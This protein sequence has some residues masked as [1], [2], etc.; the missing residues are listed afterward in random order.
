MSAEGNRT[1]REIDIREKRVKYNVDKLKEQVSL[2]EMRRDSFPYP[3]S[4]P[5]AKKEKN[6]REQVVQRQAK[7][8]Q[9]Q[10]AA[11]IEYDRQRNTVYDRLT[12]LE[13]GRRTLSNMAQ[14]GRPNAVYQRNL[15]G[16]SDPIYQWSS[17][18]RSRPLASKPRPA[19]TTPKPKRKSSAKKR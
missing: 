3:K 18:G 9:R 4:K 17:A 16:G 11:R 8:L 15:L 12:A 6:R 7:R 1:L 13:R 19:P 14:R 5:A 2:A 10:Y